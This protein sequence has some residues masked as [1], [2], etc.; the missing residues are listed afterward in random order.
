MQGSVLI[1]VIFLNESLAFAIFKEELKCNKRETKAAENLMV[2]FKILPSL[3]ELK[4]Y[5]EMA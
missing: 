2:L 4:L 3:T 5:S 1:L